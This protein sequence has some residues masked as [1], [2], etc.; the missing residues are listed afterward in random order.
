M[1]AQAQPG[2]YLIEASRV[3]RKYCRDLRRSLWYAAQDVAACFIPGRDPAV[4]RPKEF[5][6]VKDVSF[7]LRR[8]DSLGLIGHNGAGKSTLLKMLTGQRGLT[9][10]RIVRRG[11]AVALNELGLGFD[12]VMTGRE[13]AYM[14]AAVF[15]FPRKK[16][17]PIIDAIIDFAGIREFIDSPVQTY[18]SG[19]KARLG[20]SIAA[21][22]EPDILIV[23]EVLAVGDL[24]FRRKC[25][26]HILGFLRRGGSVVLVAH[27]P[28][29]IQTVCNRVIVMEKGR[30]IFD[31]PSIEGVDLHFQMG[32]ASRMK[33]STGEILERNV[34]SPAGEAGSGTR[35]RP[36]DE[37]PIVIE[38][39]AVT[40]EDG[41]G[42][43]TGRSALVT[44]RCRSQLGTQ[45]GWAFSLCTADLSTSISS[46]AIGLDGRSV[47]V[48][49]GENEFRCRIPDLPLRPGVYAVRGGVTD[50]GTFTAITLRGYQNAPG[51][52]TVES[53][54][55]D[56]DSNLRSAAN[57]LVAIRAEWL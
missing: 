17:E 24:A 55:P 45:V 48:R 19:M 41:P 27:D 7:L 47:T 33:D 53:D 18:S 5:W 56:R 9:A 36:T 49:P 26:T 22:L 54:Q 43:F 46:F 1:I 44:L 50:L 10:G 16:L 11:R 25:V 14:N 32:N 34:L 28:Y 20:F 15:D 29:L 21:H 35:P 8:G 39:L 38:D 2:E 3:S 51:F 52:F 42:L 31:G 13:N 4:L 57:D 23:D 30:A 37:Q 6:A 40:P 12:A